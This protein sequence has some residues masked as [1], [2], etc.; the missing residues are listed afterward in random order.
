MVFLYNSILHN[1]EK[2]QTIGRYDMD[3]SHRHNIEQKEP[4][5]KECILYDSIHR[6]LRT[7]KINRW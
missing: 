7:S 3:D 1:S 6:N 4:D 2:G 5:T